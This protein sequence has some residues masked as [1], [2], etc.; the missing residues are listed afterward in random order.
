MQSSSLSQIAGDT[1]RQMAVFQQKQLPSS[2][3][4]QRP[5]EHSG[6]PEVPPQAGSVTPQLAS[7]G[8]HRAPY[9]AKAGVL[10]LVRTGADQATAAPAPMRLSMRLREMQAFPSGPMA[11]S[12]SLVARPASFAREGGSCVTCG[13]CLTLPSRQG[14][15]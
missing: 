5:G 12:E 2:R 14:R 9:C 1:V 10:R 6:H 11:A 8:A 13:I 4:A 15:P 7:V 3:P